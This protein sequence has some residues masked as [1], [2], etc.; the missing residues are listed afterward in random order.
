MPEWEVSNSPSQPILFKMGPYQDHQMVVGDVHHGGLNRMFLEKINGDYQGVIFPFTQGLE[1]GMTRVTY[2]P[3]NNLYMAGLGASGD[4]GHMGQCCGLQRLSYNGKPVFDMLA[5]KARSNGME[6]EFTEPLKKGEGANEIEYAVQQ[7]W[8]ETA[9]DVPEGGVKNDIEDLPVR[10]VK[11]SADGR[12][13]FLELSGMKKEH[14]IY[15]K[16]KKPFTSST[17][18]KLWT[19]DAWYTL[20][21][22]PGE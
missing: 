7:F 10:S 13:V 15:I 1:A 21:N 17:G 22:I 19:G 2:G 6:I 4:F 8:Y 9:D 16:I 18:D 5:V 11:V 3:D 14:V 20:N 12:K